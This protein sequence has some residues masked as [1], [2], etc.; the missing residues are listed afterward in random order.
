MKHTFI[1]YLGGSAGDMFTASANGILLDENSFGHL[2]TNQHAVQDIPYSI[3]QHER[4]II[5]GSVALEQLI[6]PLPWPYISTHLYSELPDNKIN[7]VV[8]DTT[9][10][11]QIVYRQM[12]LQALQLANHSG[13]FYT[14]IDLLIT[15][16]QY[17]KAAVVWFD[18]AQK[19]AREKM[20]QRLRDT[21]SKLDFSKLFSQDFVESVQSQGWNMHL[22]ILHKNHSNWLARQPEFSK[23]LAILSME[24]K[25]INNQTVRLDVLPNPQ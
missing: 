16:G 1:S 2:Q 10:F 13:T 5:S 20:Q 18:F 22:D 12:Q 17:S 14:I 4:D 21:N 6:Q 19:H 23:E 3:K 8:S 24:K 9:T 7:V 11:D 15:K 25:L